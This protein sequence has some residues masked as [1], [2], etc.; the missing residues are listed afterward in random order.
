M[1][2]VRKTVNEVVNEALKEAIGSAMKD[3]ARGAIR[4]TMGKFVGDILNEETFNR[5]CRSISREI[6]KVVDDVMGQAFDETET[7]E[8]NNND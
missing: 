6:Y 8:D 7:K 3:S 1:N 5:Y 2:K 4:E